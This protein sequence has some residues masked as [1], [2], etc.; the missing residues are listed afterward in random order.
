MY[1]DYLDDILYK[2]SYYKD[3]NPID[4][5]NLVPDDWVLASSSF[6]NPIIDYTNNSGETRSRSNKESYDTNQSI[7]EENTA[8]FEFMS[9]SLS[10]TLYS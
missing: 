6:P 2:Y 3:L 5:L 10:E 1:K 7:E 4:I 8:L 9:Q